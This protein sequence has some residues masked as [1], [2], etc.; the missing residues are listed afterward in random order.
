MYIWL[1]LKFMKIAKLGR[2]SSSA[3]LISEGLLVQ[4][5][6]ELSLANLFNES[7]GGTV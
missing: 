1:P 6:L 5:E 3:R 7:P 4:T 2:R